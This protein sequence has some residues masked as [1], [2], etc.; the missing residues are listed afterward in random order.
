MWQFL[1]VFAISF[2]AFSSEFIEDLTTVQKEEIKIFKKAGYKNI[3][4]RKFRHSTPNQSGHNIDLSII[5]LDQNSWTEKIIFHHLS[6]INRI[7]AKCDLSLNNLKLITAISPSGT[8][9]IPYL[10]SEAT[11]SFMN[12]LQKP[13]H[14]LIFLINK[15]TEGNLGAIAGTPFFVEETYPKL[16]NTIWISSIIET[17]YYN[18]YHDMSADGISHL[19]VRNP[20]YDVWAH[21]LAH[22]LG[23]APHL[24]TDTPNLLSGDSEFLSDDITPEQCS[25]FLKHKFIIKNR[26]EKVF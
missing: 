6:E 20:N 2:S 4:I 7:Y 26:V 19:R 1:I 14:P 12:K 22:L 21:E 11:N 15:F 3:N 13:N 17:P 23:N 25:I 10:K 8:N 9:K 18:T 16:L 5:N 24:T